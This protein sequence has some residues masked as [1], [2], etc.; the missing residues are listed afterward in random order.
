MLAFDGIPNSQQNK[1]LFVGCMDPKTSEQDL[2]NY[3]GCFDQY[4]QVKLLW[5]TQ[6]NTSKQCA[7]LFCS[8]VDTA[9]EI[10]KAPH[11]VHD[12]NLRVKVADEERKGTKVA[13]LY[14][15][16]VSGIPVDTPC[17]E[18]EYA[19]SQYP[20]YHSFRFIHGIHHKQKWVAKVAFKNHASMKN[21]LAAQ[22]HVII[23]QKLCKIVE[24]QPKGSSVGSDTY[25]S[26][27]SCS[28]DE[29][30]QMRGRVTKLDQ[31][32]FGKAQFLEQV[33]SPELMQ[34]VGTIYPY[35]VSLQEFPQTNILS[36]SNPGRMPA[37]LTPMKLSASSPNSKICYNADSVQAQKGTRQIF[38]PELTNEEDDDLFKLFAGSTT[39]KKKP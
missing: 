14:Y 20:D 23:A 11:R 15:L 10:L 9:N 6:T 34:P 38:V 1:T 2:F 26:T 29:N 24:F 8:S 30:E 5:N 7:L 13:Q 4:I 36:R 35:A 27:N 18:I 19:F 21:L 31:F 22:T 32:S 16:Q 33:S 3:F 17:E 12:R 39:I 25:S 28:H 37:K